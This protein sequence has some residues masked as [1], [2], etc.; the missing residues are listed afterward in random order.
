MLGAPFRVQQQILQA[1]DESQ[2]GCASGNLVLVGQQLLEGGFCVVRLLSVDAR[3]CTRIHL[4]NAPAIGRVKVFLLLLFALP[5]AAHVCR[6]GCAEQ[7]H[8]E[9]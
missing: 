5:V 4:A 2:L 8:G 1:Q 9:V 3:S 6:A 7:E